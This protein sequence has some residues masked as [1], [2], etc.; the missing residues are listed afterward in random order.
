MDDL[1]RVAEELSISLSKDDIQQA[2]QEK[3]KVLDHELTTMNEREKKSEVLDPELKT[4]DLPARDIENSAEH[5]SLSV[6]QILQNKHEA[7]VVDM[8]NNQKARH[9]TESKQE[10]CQ[11][12]M[13]ALKQKH[14][15][16]EKVRRV[17]VNGIND[18]STAT[19]A[20]NFIVLAFTTLVKV[21][22]VSA[23]C[24]NPFTLVAVLGLACLYVGYQYHKRQQTSNKKTSKNTST[25]SPSSPVSFWGRHSDQTTTLT[26]NDRSASLV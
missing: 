12:K 13:T 9:I 15:T 6:G 16:R 10:Q 20:L 17:I 7:I 8:D 21:A 19:T 1:L 23:A 25:V 11:Q 4:T 14:A 3:S 2:L 18:F 5:S 24:S 26:A 22:A